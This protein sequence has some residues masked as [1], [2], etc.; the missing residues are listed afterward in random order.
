[1]LSKPNTDYEF[2]ILLSTINSQLLNNE[3]NASNQIGMTIPVTIEVP[4][5]N[6]SIVVKINFYIYIYLNIYMDILKLG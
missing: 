5:E 1:M 6:V 4:M 3:L 2:Y